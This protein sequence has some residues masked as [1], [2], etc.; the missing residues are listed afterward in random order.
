[1]ASAFMLIV[2]IID[3]WFF[4]DELRAVGPCGEFG[5]LGVHRSFNVH[6]CAVGRSVVWMATDFSDLS[7]T[8]ISITVPPGHGVVFL[9]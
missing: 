8:D 9:V 5:A 7:V 1:M 2:I 6:W 4:D 3:V